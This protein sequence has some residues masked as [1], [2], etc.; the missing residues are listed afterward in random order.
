MSDIQINRWAYTLVH[1]CLD[2]KPGDI[3]AIQATPQASPLIEAVYREALQVGAQPVPVIELE[4]LEEILLRE[5]NDD[6]LANSSPIARVLAEQ[7]NARLVISSR[8]NPRALN[9]IDPA[10]TAKYHQSLSPLSKIYRQREQAG[11]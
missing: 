1:Y 6:Q 8:N 11:A 4:S 5:G 7:A 2:L 9:N 10:R 3:F